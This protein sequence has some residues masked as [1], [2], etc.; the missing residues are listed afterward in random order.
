MTTQPAQIDP[1]S[2]EFTG[3][4]PD[5]NHTSDGRCKYPASC[6]AEGHLR[7]C[8]EGVDSV[9]AHIEAI[10]DQAGLGVMVQV[11]EIIRDRESVTDDALLAL[12]ADDVDAFYTG[13]LARAIDD[14]ERSIENP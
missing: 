5:D 10:C 2:P 11:V 14:I 13:F 4:A 7:E 3:H 9:S 8:T 12:D 6:A 1:S